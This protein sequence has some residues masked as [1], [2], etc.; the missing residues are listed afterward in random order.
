MIVIAKIIITVVSIVIIVLNISIA[1]YIGSMIFI[2]FW[3]IFNIFDNIYSVVIIIIIV[4]NIVFIVVKNDDNYVKI[5]TI[6]NN[7]VNV[8]N[9]PSMLLILWSMSL[10]LSSLQFILFHYAPLSLYSNFFSVFERFLF[11]LLIFSEHQWKTFA[12]IQIKTKQTLRQTIDVVLI[13][14][15]HVRI[16]IDHKKYA[17]KKDAFTQARTTCQWSISLSNDIFMLL[18]IFFID[19]I[20]CASVFPIIFTKTTKKFYWRCFADTDVVFFTDV[21]TVPQRK[22]PQMLFSATGGKIIQNSLER[23]YLRFWN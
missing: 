19:C 8:V 1:S 10:I 13:F 11:S 5:T 6:V 4:V 17:R 16:L 15:D 20:D 21:V 14:V 2:L 3:S 7:H 12:K 22:T 9:I 18:L 23:F